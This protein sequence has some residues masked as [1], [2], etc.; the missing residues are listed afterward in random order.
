MDNVVDAKAEVIEESID[1]QTGLDRWLAETKDR[2][3]AMIGEYSVYEVT[4][5]DLHRQADRD[6]KSMNAS[7]K[8]VKAERMSIT[9]ILDDAKRK[10]M[11]AEREATSELTA[12]R[13]ALKANDDR[14]KADQVAMKTAKLREA[15]ED[16]AP[17]LA[18]PMNG[19]D[20]LVPFDL[21]ERTFGQGSLGKRWSN[22]G[23]S[24]AEAESQLMKAITKIAD[25]EATIASTV[26][27]EDVPE[28][29]AAYFGTLDLSAAMKMA[30]ERQEQRERVKA[31]EQERLAREQERAAREKAEQER[32]EEQQMAELKEAWERNREQVVKE[33][34]PLEHYVDKLSQPKPGNKVPEYVFFAYCRRDQMPKV[35]VA[36]NE[37]G[38]HGTARLT[39][40]KRYHLE[41]D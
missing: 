22:Y 31:L 19:N 27:E 4:D 17:D 23:T 26:A 33:P 38:V 5:L 8:D 24:Y 28:V 21:V 16:A 36:M 9:R 25:D 30:R 13:E 10:V 41:E 29:K 7:L 32:A 2:I 40:G 18:L 35:K 39:K 20:P 37:I 15:Y 11:D 12:L 3:S 1:V 14:Y 34:T 6:L